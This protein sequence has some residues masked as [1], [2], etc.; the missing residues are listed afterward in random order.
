[1]ARETYKSAT[2]GCYHLDI[3][4]DDPHES[5][6]EWDNIGTMVCFHGR[7]NLGD[8]NHGYKKDNYDS[9]EELAEAIQEEHD[10]VVIKPLYLYDHSGITISTGQ[11]NCRWDSGQIGFIFCSREKCIE[12]YGD[13]SPES[14]AKVESYLD[15]EV[16]TYD[17]YLTGDVYRFKLVKLVKREECGHV[18][19]EYLDSCGGLYG[20]DFKTNGLKENISTD[21]EGVTEAVI[22]ELIERLS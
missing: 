9:W 14:I 17:L 20:D 16:K 1:M 22:D 15:G 7:Y 12:E 5:P 3:F 21:D 18:E 11:F 4:Q 6:R 13:D 8:T 2:V 10:P 19:D